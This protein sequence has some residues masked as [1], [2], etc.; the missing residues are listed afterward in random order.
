MKLK[1][2]YYITYQ[3]FPAHTANSIQTISNIKHFVRNNHNVTLYFPLRQKDSIGDIEKIQ[4]FYSFTD[5]FVVRGVKHYL[6]FGRID[7]FK[8]LNFHFSHFLWSFWVC[9]FLINNDAEPDYYFTRSDWVLFFLSLRNKKVIFECHQYSKVRKFVINKA[10]KRPRT[11]IVFLSEN[12]CKRFELEGIPSS[13]SFVAQNGFDDDFYSIRNTPVKNSL[14]FLGSLRRFNEDR[15]L[16]LLI[17][18]FK[19]PEINKNYSLTLVGGPEEEVLKLNE[20]INKNKITASIDI[21][22][23]KNRKDISKYLSKSEIGLLLNSSLNTHSFLFSSPLKYFEY[24]CNDMQV[25]AVDFPAHHALPFS[26]KI[27]FFQENNLD[28][29]INAI[30]SVDVSKQLSQEEYNS[31]TVDTRVKNLINFFEE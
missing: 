18:A 11:K 8:K 10:I 22:G 28:S 6:P 17:D 13:K 7:Y 12:L 23:P 27:K 1:N 4:E 9:L 31:L 14:L 30:K 2:I 21:T 15:G 19:D 26:N 16:K 3:S 20:Y 25:V 29:L 24:I 5:N